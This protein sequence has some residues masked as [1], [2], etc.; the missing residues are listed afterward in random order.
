M[1][2]LR[3]EPTYFVSEQYCYHVNGLGYACYM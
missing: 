1:P 2:I 3:L